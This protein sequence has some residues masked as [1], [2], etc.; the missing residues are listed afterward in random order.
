MLGFANMGGTWD[1]MWTCPKL[2]CTIQPTLA[3]VA[4]GRVY[5]RI[6]DQ[7]IKLKNQVTFLL[8]KKVFWDPRNLHW[9]LDPRYMKK[10][11]SGT[12][13]ASFRHQILAVTTQ[14]NIAPRLGDLT[15]SLGPISSPI[16]KSIEGVFGWMDPKFVGPKPTREPTLKVGLHYSPCPTNFR[17]KTQLMD[18]S[19]ELTIGSSN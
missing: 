12:I 1:L 13:V 4:L 17:S 11:W 16:V 8:V 15:L 2:A 18:F 7:I 19:F 9:G 5:T 3:L 6:Q 10:L 14:D